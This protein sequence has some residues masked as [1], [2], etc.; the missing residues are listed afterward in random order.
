MSLVIFLSDNLTHEGNTRFIKDNQERIKTK[1][2]NF[3][4]WTRHPEASEILLSFQPKK[5]NALIFDH[6]LLHD[7]SQI[8]DDDGKNN[9]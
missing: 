8:K 3:S 1:D 5:G 4:D 6:R 9:Y 7:S 2:R